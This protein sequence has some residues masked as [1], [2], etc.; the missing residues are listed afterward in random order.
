MKEQ[1]TQE[2][3]QEKAEKFFDK[4]N[5]ALAKEFYEKMFASLS[6]EEI[7]KKI[8]VCNQALNKDKAKR[9]LKKAKKFIKK[10]HFDKA[11]E[12]YEEAYELMPEDYILDSIKK[13]K[14]E[15]EG[16][17]LLFSAE[18]AEKNKDFAKAAIC[19]QKAFDA[20]K[21]FELLLRLSMNLVLISKCDIAKQLIDENQNL[22]SDKLSE[23][24][25]YEL[26]YIF[27]KTAEYE[28]CL[29]LWQNIKSKSAEFAEQ[30]NAVINLFEQQLYD[31]YKTDD[32]KTIKKQAEF[33]NKIAKSATIYDILQSSKIAQAENLCKEKKYNEALKLLPFN[34]NFKEEY[35]MFYAQLYFNLM[36]EK[37]YNLINQIDAINFIVTVMSNPKYPTFIEGNKRTDKLGKI[38]N[39]NYPFIY[40][41][42]NIIIANLNLITSHLNNDENFLYSIKIA[43]LLNLSDEIYKKILDDSDK[44]IDEKIL[45]KIE[46]ICNPKLLNVY[47][48]VYNSQFN[49]KSKIADYKNEKY[50]KDLENDLNYQV[51]L[52]AYENN[53]D[54]NISKYMKLVGDYFLDDEIAATL[55]GH[56]PPEKIEYNLLEAFDKIFSKH[57]N[58][59]LKPLALSSIYKYKVYKEVIELENCKNINKI[60]RLLT[61]L[62]YTLDKIWSI[63]A[64]TLDVISDVDN[65]KKIE[66]YFAYKHEM[67]ER[68]VDV[69]QYKIRE[70]IYHAKTQVAA[71]IVLSFPD[72][73]RL[74]ETFFETAE[75]VVDE[76]I[77]ECPFDCDY[78]PNVR[79]ILAASIKVN[80]YH[81]YIIELKDILDMEYD[82][83]IDSECLDY[84]SRDGD[85]EAV[86][87]ELKGKIE[88]YFSDNPDAE[89]RIKKIM[90]EEMK[91]NKG[92]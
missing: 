16:K 27:A 28:K 6:D 42:A 61:N 71:Q 47:N 75:T 87:P 65:R 48:D 51:F 33:I 72:S 9:I 12:A 85:E 70:G 3:L 38:F 76:V 23:Q 1:V 59:K 43:S 2:E 66:E 18:A 44:N 31:N 13:L 46:M 54:K 82:V 53:K 40:S 73:E 49:F 90:I 86:D 34:K 4:K 52:V 64:E 14:G 81:P 67:F 29:T 84:Y 24:E 78:K 15:E 83:D 92:K 11:L 60:P 37:K 69:A 20:K 88:E 41:Y 91:K 58:G 10:K 77:E 25:K 17:E 79:K 80:P 26:G 63:E 7:I 19:Y 30:K 56:F 68:T 57:L 35:I 32:F 5:Y 89:K 55:E 62:D 36:K 22:I 8:E 50:Y 39:K 74:E 45:E 21:S